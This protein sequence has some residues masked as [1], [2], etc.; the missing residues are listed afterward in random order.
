MTISPQAFCQKVYESAKTIAVEAKRSGSLQAGDLQAG[1]LVRAV[2]DYD[3]TGVTLAKNK[4]AV[5]VLIEGAKGLKDAEILERLS[6]IYDVATW[7]I[8]KPN[9]L[10]IDSIKNLKKLG[11][12]IT[13]T[14]MQHTVTRA[15]VKLARD[16]FNEVISLLT[17][18]SGT[19][20][21]TVVTTV[22]TNATPDEIKNLLRRSNVLEVI[23]EVLSQFRDT[24][25]MYIKGLSLHFRDEV[26]SLMEDLRK[27]DPKK[28]EEVGAAVAR[29]QTFITKVT[30]WKNAPKPLKALQAE[31]DMVYKSIT[32]A[33]ATETTAGTAPSTSAPAE[34]PAEAMAAAKTSAAE[35]PEK[36][37]TSTTEPITLKESTSE[38][39]S[40]LEEKTEEQI[41]DMPQSD[42]IA[43]APK[44]KLDAAPGYAI[45]AECGAALEGLRDAAKPG[46]IQKKNGKAIE[47]LLEG[48]SDEAIKKVLSF[49]EQTPFADATKA[50]MTK[51]FE[52]SDKKWSRKAQ[53]K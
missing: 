29:L 26:V 20:D 13:E 28:K 52:L 51:Y 1:D 31:A 16:R 12:A 30:G 33:L 47:G 24:C 34:A 48:S 3:L 50:N 44:K 14:T 11:D 49:I 18:K 37:V 9:E 7:N 17:T 32:E 38:K 15:T 40:T 19:R 42:T 39:P 36:T 5:E 2:R 8:P 6:I 35:V 41:A 22:A 45:S 27:K 43:E 53:Y 23:G 10:T 25:K 21:T 4:E 46:T